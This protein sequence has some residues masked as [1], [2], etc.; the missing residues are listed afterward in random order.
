MADNRKRT[1]PRSRNSGKA[2]QMSLS[3][4]FK[5][6]RAAAN[7][8]FKP[9]PETST[10]LKTSRMTLQQRLRLT[11]W[12]LYI[13]TCIL[14]LVVQDVILSQMP[15][16]GACIDLPVCAILLITVLEGSE[17][18]SLFVLISALVYYFSGTAP[19]AWCIALLTFL[20]VG[21]TL[22]R[23]MYWHRSRGSVL[24]C[25]MIALSAYEMSLF[26]TGLMNELTVPGRIGSFALTSLYSCLA[27][28]PLYSLIYKIGLIGGN[29]WKE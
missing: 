10:W 12:L 11:K 13:F 24:L 2:K 7:M 20:G 25:T 23:Q 5:K 9:D 19:T 21:A 16:F 6:R 29:T 14:C 17:V 4:L 3:E 1:P 26:V 22:L 18:G 27:L 15:L 8:D 28:I